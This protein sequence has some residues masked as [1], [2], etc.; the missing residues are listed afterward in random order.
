MS[1]GPQG[2]HDLRL[3]DR[4]SGGSVDL[5]LTIARDEKGIKQWR[6]LRAAQF[7]AR[8]S[9]GPISADDKDPR[10]DFTWEQDDWSDGA[11]RPYYRPGDKRYAQSH[12]TDLRWPGVVAMGMAIP[13]RGTMFIRNPNAEEGGT[14][15]WTAH[16]NATIS[17]E[18]TPTPESGTYSFQ[19]TT[20]SQTAGDSMMEQTF[21]TPSAWRSVTCTAIAYIRLASGSVGIQL[22]LRD[23]DGTTATNTTSSPDVTADAWTYASV[24]HTFQN[25]ATECAV[26]FIPK[27]A[28]AQLILFV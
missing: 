27:L 13:S 16:A 15:G 10:V 6:E 19:I 20:S 12:L 21:A 18:T 26:A 14:G 8:S 2:S 22:R 7:P 25:D 23:T 28:L 17:A 24:S 3:Q 9:S 5:N 11:L 1:V 4:P